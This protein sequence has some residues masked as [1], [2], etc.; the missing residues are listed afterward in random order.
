MHIP[1]RRAES[2]PYEHDDGKNAIGETVCLKVRRLTDDYD[3]PPA[4]ASLGA[5]TE[6]FV[7]LRDC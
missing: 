3:K 1:L 4:R 7:E 2:G 5:L 6:D